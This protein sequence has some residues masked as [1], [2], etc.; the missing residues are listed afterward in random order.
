MANNNRLPV[1][2][3]IKPN[4]LLPKHLIIP[5]A[6]MHLYKI[7]LTNYCIGNKTIKRHLINNPIL[8]FIMSLI[9]VIL[10]II[11]L[12]TSVENKDLFYYIGDWSS[13]IPGVRI[14]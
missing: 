3:Q 6:G 10:L 5:D 1:N 7:G 8:I 4:K 12:C 11:S 14:H 13:F 9:E 2:Q